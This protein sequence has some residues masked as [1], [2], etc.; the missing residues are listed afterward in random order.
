MEAILIKTEFGFK[1]NDLNGVYIASVAMGSLSLKNC[2]VIESGYD[3]DELAEKESQLLP[4]NSA[5]DLEKLH[6]RIGFVRGAKAILELLGD[7]KFSEAEMRKAYRKGEE[8][9]YN[10]GGLTKQKEGRYIQSLQQT[11]WDVEVEMDA[12]TTDDISSIIGKPKFDSDGC[13]ILKRK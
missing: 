5:T 6:L 8:D 1:L 13:L 10:Q 9:S 7:K 2:Q 11:E 4:P 12:I 3:L